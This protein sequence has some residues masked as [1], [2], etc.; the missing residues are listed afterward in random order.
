MHF[1]VN[2]TN[3]LKLT[4]AGP[5]RAGPVQ[6]GPVQDGPVQ[7][8]PALYGNRINPLDIQR[9]VSFFFSESANKTP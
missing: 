6:A 7:D 3:N 2:D 9:A 5:V 1:L 8:G 4:Q